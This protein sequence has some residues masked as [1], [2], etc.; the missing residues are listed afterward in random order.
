MR[1]LPALGCS[2]LLLALAGASPA[3]SQ[4]GCT[5]TPSERSVAGGDTVPTL[6]VDCDPAVEPRLL[7]LDSARAVCQSPSLP[8]DHVSACER[9]AAAAHA[10]YRRAAIR[11]ALRQGATEQE[12]V[13]AFQASTDEIEAAEGSVL[14]TAPSE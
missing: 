11:A 2:L 10:A 4:T 6:V 14:V 1:L 5:K 12:L 8:P 7:D 9:A 13:D 3:S